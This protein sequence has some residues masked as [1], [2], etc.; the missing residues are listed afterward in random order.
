MVAG[1]IAFG[2]YLYF[3]VGIDELFLSLQKINTTEYLFFF[4]LAIASMVLALFCWA[5]SWKTILR[6]LSVN[7]NIKKSFTIFM[8]GYFLDLVIPSETIGSELTRLYLVHHETQGDLGAIA[9]SAVTN[10]IVEY[11]IVAVGLSSSV[12]VLISSGN[13]PSLVSGFLYLVLVGVL[14]YLTILLFLALKERAAEVIVSIGLR[15]LRFL[16]LRR[17]S[18]TNT[19]RSKASLVVFYNGFKTFRQNPE[20]LAKPLILQ[21]F[22]FLFNIAVYVLVFEALGI[23][24]LS[25]GFFVLAFFIASAIQGA[26]AS[27]SVG[28]L[29]IILVTVF[30]LY[31][32][33]P[34][35]SGIAVIMLRTVTYW[36]PLLASYA[37]IQVYG[38]QN[39][40]G[41]RPKEDVKPTIAPKEDDT[42]RSKVNS[43]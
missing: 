18:S 7:L 32:I 38:V 26:T 30:I 17:Y 6:T 2:L 3:F 16:R 4:S 23:Q 14:V 35:I 11:S 42:S 27:L 41:P 8:V 10:R 21:L 24:N 28:S 37:M 43:K 20:K 22:S 25:L 29:D 33:P 36:F 15:L 19:D 34:A 31:G 5:A 13:V 39:I 40:L 1:L 9:A 12:L